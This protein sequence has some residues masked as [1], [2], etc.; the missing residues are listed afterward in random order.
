MP[1]YRPLLGHRSSKLNEN[2]KSIITF[3]AHQAYKDLPVMIPCGQ[4]I[5]CKTDKSNEWAAR[6]YH[7]ARMHK[8]N[9]FVTLTYDPINIPEGGT[10]VKS[11]LQ[12]FMKRL[13]EKYEHPIRFFACGEY[14]DAFNRPH[15]HLLLFGHDFS[16]KRLHSRNKKPGQHLYRSDTLELLWPQGFSTIGLFDIA[17]AKY[18]AAYT[19]KKVIG[20]EQHEHY[21]GKLPE[22]ALM[23]RTRDWVG[24][25]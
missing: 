21:K 18:V 13:R 8:D 14:G 9:C 20:K 23:S 15:Y 25:G 19:A 7:E 1:C 22:F 17:S 3:S 12:K 11:D 24:N 6:C 10:L 5:G 16:D 2:G 4:C